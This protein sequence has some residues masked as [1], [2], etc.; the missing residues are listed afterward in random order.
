MNDINDS[1]ILDSNSPFSKKHVNIDEVIE[2]NKSVFEKLETQTLEEYQRRLSEHEAEQKKHND[3]AAKYAE[4][5]SIYDKIS[6]PFAMH[7]QTEAKIRNCFVEK[8]K[9]LQKKN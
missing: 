8:L 3:S 2:R 6:G 4:I 7:D 5:L 1:N 9:Y